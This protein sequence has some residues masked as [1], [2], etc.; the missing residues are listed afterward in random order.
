MIRF[1][2]LHFLFE[3][4]LAPT[5]KS[6][7]TLFLFLFFVELQSYFVLKRHGLQDEL[8]ADTPHAYLKHV[9]FMQASCFYFHFFFVQN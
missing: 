5:Y 3:S 6:N 4:K 8:S 1:N 7:I 9:G 2:L